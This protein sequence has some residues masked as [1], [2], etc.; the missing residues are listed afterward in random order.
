M[1][2][3]MSTGNETVPAMR[4]ALLSVSDKKGLAALA[5]GLAAAQVE[6]IST[7]GTAAYLRELGLKVITVSDVTGFPEIMGGRVK[8]LHP[9]I[10]GG[11]LGRRDQDADVMREQA[12]GPIDLVVVNL[13]PFRETVADPGRS[14][15]EAVE[16][17]DIGG[18]AM[19]RAAAKNHRWVTTLVDPV[20]YAV[21][22][23]DLP[24]PPCE[25]TRRDLAAKAYAHTAA[26]DAAITAYLSTGDEIEDHPAGH[27]LPERINVCLSRRR[28]LRY[29]ENPHQSAALYTIAA[30]ASETCAGTLAG[31]DPLQGKPL[32]FNNLLDADA[33][34]NLARQWP[35]ASACI[36]VKHGNPCGAA[37]A[38]NSHAAY[39]RAFAGDPQSAFG[40]IIAFS[41]PVDGETATAVLESQFAEV[42]VAP[43]FTA[44]ARQCFAAKQNL[45]LLAI[46]ESPAARRVTGDDPG[47]FEFR[48]INGGM[49]V[50]Q[51]DAATTARDAWRVVSQ[52]TPTE[53]EWRDL[54]FSWQVVRGVKSNA[55]VYAA[56]GRTLGIGAGQMSRVDSARLARQKAAAAK[57]SLQ[58]A[59]MASDAFFPFPDSIEEAAQAGIRAIIQPGGSMRDEQVIAAANAHDMAMVLTDR[60][61]FRH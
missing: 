45:R 59:A 1:V 5:Q 42:I 53:R 10:H 7:G 32:S 3:S 25:K 12:I 52:R 30:A 60:R 27:E 56:D 47:E 34:W 38:E 16:N 41:Q 14:D 22:L 18:P 15:Q 44:A 36:I 29:G 49:L 54:A 48:R 4:R 20:D 21:V 11:I 28:A 37:I 24:R 33:A 6:L 55:I 35:D 13:Y 58:G 9:R 31:A 39:A 57:L 2:I 19:I 50:Q 61:H 46:G 23:N 17:I 26:Y 40:G 51:L 8:T 43:A